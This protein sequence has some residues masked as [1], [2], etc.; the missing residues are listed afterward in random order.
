MFWICCRFASRVIAKPSRQVHSVDVFTYETQPQPFDMECKA[1]R[2]VLIEVLNVTCAAHVAT[3]K[4]KGML[5]QQKE[6]N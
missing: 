4:M 5:K 6:E 1:G 3:R 2:Q